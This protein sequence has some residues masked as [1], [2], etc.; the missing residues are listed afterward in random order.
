MGGRGSFS[1]G[2]SSFG[3]GGSRS[4]GGGSSS[5]GSS[6]GGSG[7]TTYVPVP[8]PMG[9]RYGYNSYGGGRTSSDAGIT[10][11]A[12]ICGGIAL[13]FV[14]VVIYTV[15]KQYRRKNGEDDDTDSDTVRVARITLGIQEQA[16]PLV[17]RLH[18]LAEHVDVDTAQGRHQLLG[19]T[20][21]MTHKYLANIEFGALEQSKLLPPLE[22]ERQFGRWSGEARLTYDR[23][24]VRADELGVQTETR[25]V[26]TDGIRDEDGQLAVHEYFVLVIVVA[27]RGPALPSLTRAADID[28]VVGTLAAMSG[29]DLIAVEIVWSPDARSDAMDRDD[30]ET[31]F[32]QLRPL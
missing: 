18:A 15:Y 7:R 27:H 14:I 13:V 19:R 21:A 29:R 1:R 5:S 28:Q 24:T 26:A 22:A 23:E 9:P 11:F 6:W 2:S 31:R 16:W 17:D 10:I 3:G 12:I 4:F 32:A 25:E 8:I 30:M 20:V